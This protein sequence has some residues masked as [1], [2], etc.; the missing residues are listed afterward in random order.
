MADEK[1]QFNVYLPRELIR[2]VKHEAIDACISLSELVERALR[3]YLEH[4]AST[5]ET[6]FR[7]SKK[8]VGKGKT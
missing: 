1:Q 5:S 2:E 4:P 8:T 3:A 6:V 7:A